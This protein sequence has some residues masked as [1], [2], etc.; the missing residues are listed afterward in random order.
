M[1]FRDI[2]VG[3]TVYIKSTVRVGWHVE[4]AFTVPRK[5]TKITATQFAIET[6][7]RYMKGTG[8]RI[9]GEY[10]ERCFLD[11]EDQTAQMQQFKAHF[12]RVLAVRN[13][14]RSAKV[15]HE[16]SPEVLDQLEKALALLG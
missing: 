13:K 5:V 15:G 12:K 4:K 10:L 16:V 8:F 3:D 6:G 1:N 11:G 14:L 9:G 2:K 7:E